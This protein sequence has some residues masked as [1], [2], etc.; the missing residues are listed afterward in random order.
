MKIFIKKQKNF[1]L[2]KLLR[3]CGYREFKDQQSGQISFTHRLGLYF[4]PRFHLYIV[5]E[6]PEEIILSIHLD[7]KKPSY[8]GC[9]AHSADY[10]SEVV[11]KEARRINKEIKKQLTKI[12]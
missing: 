6:T 1:D 4:Y 9:P 2:I 5:K 8:P 11:R 12:I 7:Q 3:R 10:E